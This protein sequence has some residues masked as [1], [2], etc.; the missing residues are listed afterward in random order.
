L[1]IIDICFFTAILITYI[2]GVPLPKFFCRRGLQWRR[3]HL[4]IFLPKCSSFIDWCCYYTQVSY[5]GSWEPLVFYLV[6]LEDLSIVLIFYG[7]LF[8][9][10]FYW[11]F[12]IF[13]TV[14]QDK[15]LSHIDFL[16][17]KHYSLSFQACLWFH[18]LII[19]VIWILHVFLNEEV[20]CKFHH[21]L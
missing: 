12:G 6:C 8:E 15:T 5:T 13:E 2:K 10:T 16:C 21:K 17:R 9:A 14:A 3:L 1:R 7:D 20:D 18:V 19:F 4:L 11:A